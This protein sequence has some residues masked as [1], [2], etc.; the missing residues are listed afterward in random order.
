MSCERGGRQAVGARIELGKLRRELRLELRAQYLERLLREDGAHPD[1]EEDVEDGGADDR[2]E[3]DGRLRE[4]ADERGEELGRR[5]ARRH[6]RGA[7]DVGRHLQRL[8]EHVERRHK[9]LVADDRERQED[10]GDADDVEDDPA[11]AELLLGKVLFVR[12][13]EAEQL[14]RR[15]RLSRSCAIEDAE[16]SGDADEREER[17]RA[18]VEAVAVFEREGRRG[19]RRQHRGGAHEVQA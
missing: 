9:V 19:E 6:E 2:A 1:D 5:A 17:G 18:E 15:R 3:A 8:D 16:K 7:R 13:R 12:L 4:R 11:G 14:A 10:V